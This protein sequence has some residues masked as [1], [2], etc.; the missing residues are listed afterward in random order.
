ML[1]GVLHSLG[2]FAPLCR[3][4]RSQEKPVWAVRVYLDQSSLFPTTLHGV[5]NRGQR[6][7]KS[8]APPWKLEDEASDSAT[9]ACQLCEGCQTTAS[10]ARDKSRAGQCGQ[11]R[12][13]VLK[14][15]AGWRDERMKECLWLSTP[16]RYLQVQPKATTCLHPLHARLAQAC[17]WMTVC[18]QCCCLA[19]PTP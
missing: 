5:Q 16:L 17:T 18:P 15:R 13:G 2:F 7:W 4:K 1:R 9:P 6:V 10:L 3:I 19:L 14:R 12:K 11:N 8:P